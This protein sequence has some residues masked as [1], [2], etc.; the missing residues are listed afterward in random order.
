MRLSRSAALAFS[1]LMVASGV[2]KADFKYTQSSKITGGTLMKMTKALG[3]FSKS[4]RQINEP[5]L[6]TIMVRGNRMRSEHSDGT[7]QVIDLDG[8]RFINID[9]VHKAYSTMTF[10]EFRTALQN[11][12]Q[13]AKEEQEKAVEKHPE[14][15]NIKITP[16]LHSEATGATRT[17]LD[18]PTKEMKWQIEMQIESTDPK[19]QEK[20]Q[21]ASMTMNSDAWIAPEVPGYD[22]VRQFYVRM[23]KQL[24]WLPSTMGS[25]MGMNPQ[26]GPAMQEFQKNLATV[27]GMPL[28]QNV[29]FGMSATGVPQNTSATTQ[30]P[31]PPPPSDDQ[32][33]VPTSARDAISKG[34]GGAFG[35]F[36]KK[37]KKQDQDQDA[38]AP[39]S[40]GSQQPTSA[41]ASL[42]EMQIEVTG[43]STSPVDRDL[44]D[45]PAGYSQVQQDPNQV[46]GGARKQ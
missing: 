31:P 18:L 4:A 27:K 1:I 2:S 23:A 19:V 45:I 24:D 26:M 44:F 11:A 25:M 17:I 13:R 20:A 16:K 22:E 5:Q 14:A 3:V 15:S 9:T 32:A 38:Q 12:Q 33:S 37:K 21:S 30:Q 46:F 40:D 28:L 35:G 10:E 6:S 29:S 42:M 36:R 39:P 8:R 41:S 43:Y 34:F 7:V